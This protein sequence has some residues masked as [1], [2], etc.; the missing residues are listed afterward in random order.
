MMGI[1]LYKQI[2]KIQDNIS[3]NEEHI[4]FFQ[5]SET[6]LGFKIQAHEGINYYPSQEILD[7]LKTKLKDRFSELGFDNLPEP[8]MFFVM[9]LI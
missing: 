7:R 4:E 8:E 3:Y 5:E 6:L 9:S 1:E 2:L